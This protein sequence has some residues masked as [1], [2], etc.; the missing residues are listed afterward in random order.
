MKFLSFYIPKVLFRHSI[1]SMI[2]A[3]ITNVDGIYI[4]IYIYIYLGHEGEAEGEIR[5]T[6]EQLN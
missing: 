2:F 5:Y 4:Y 1:I 3:A 6:Y